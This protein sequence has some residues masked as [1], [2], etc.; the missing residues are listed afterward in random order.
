[1]QNF[2]DINKQLPTDSESARVG[3]TPRTANGQQVPNWPGN[4]ARWSFHTVLLP[5]REHQQMYNDFLDKWMLQQTCPWDAGDAFNTTPQPDLKCP[6]DEQYSYVE[7]IGSDNNSMQ[8]GSLQPTN[9]H[10]NRGDYMVD[11][12]WWECRGVFG[13]GGL[14]SSI[15]GWSPMA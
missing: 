2:H 8:G 15:M 9:Y 10:G 1:M 4:S 6:S 3:N 5:Y 13:M 14:R 7:D 12:C 11:N